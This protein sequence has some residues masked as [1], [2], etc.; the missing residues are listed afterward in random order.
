[1]LL[2]QLDNDTGLKYLFLKQEDE[3]RKD[4][5]VSGSDFSVSPPQS[6]SLYLWVCIRLRETDSDV[7]LFL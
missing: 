3:T 2:L 5:C 6:V 7:I 1:M 4:G